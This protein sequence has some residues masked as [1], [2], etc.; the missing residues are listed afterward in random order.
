[1][2]ERVG[3]RLIARTRALRTGRSEGDW[4]EVLDGLEE[5]DQVVYDGQFAL[6]DGSV[7]NLE[8]DP[9]DVSADASE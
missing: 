5:G 6:E 3:D 4:V 7:V 8:G 1:M 2:L 9:L